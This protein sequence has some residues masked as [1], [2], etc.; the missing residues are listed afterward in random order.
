MAD[1]K[2]PAEAKALAAMQL[3]LPHL[4]QMRELSREMAD[5]QKQYIARGDTTSAEGMTAVGMNLGQRLIS[6][7][8]ARTIIGQL[9]G[10][11]IERNVLANLPEQN[12]SFLQDQSPKQKTAALLDQRNV[13]QEDAKLFNSFIKSASEADLVNY[14]D[15]M[16]LSGEHN[17]FEWIRN[18]VPAQ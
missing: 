10:I 9:V 11:A 6:G 12:Y 7:D 3:I 8:G 5:L 15:R 18:R 16:K 17:A 13:L 2:S 1:G 14:F 4:I